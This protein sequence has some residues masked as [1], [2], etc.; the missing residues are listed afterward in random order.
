DLLG[1]CICGTCLRVRAQGTICFVRFLRKAGNVPTALDVLEQA[2][3]LEERPWSTAS[4]PGAFLTSDPCPFLSGDPR[5]F[6]TGDP[7]SFLSGDPRSFLTRDSC[8][9]LAR[10]L[11]ARSSSTYGD[12]SRKLVKSHA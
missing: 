6:L 7:R 11:R 9:L 12:G 1:S 4:Q 10:D 5:A 8:P 3:A 2:H